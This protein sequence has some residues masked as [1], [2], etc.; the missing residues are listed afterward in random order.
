METSFSFFYFFAL[1]SSCRDHLRLAFSYKIRKER[2]N[3]T[4]TK[5]IEVV[6]MISTVKFIINRPFHWS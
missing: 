3:Q 1:I 5:A 6:P 4:M 2:D